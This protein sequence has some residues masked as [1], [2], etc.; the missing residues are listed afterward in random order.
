MKNKSQVEQTID[1]F[2]AGVQLTTKKLARLI[3]CGSATSVLKRAI[4][5]LGI[6]WRLFDGI[7]SRLK[8]GHYNSERG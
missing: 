1:L 4:E 6:D 2:L 5:T 3:R 8:A 7:K